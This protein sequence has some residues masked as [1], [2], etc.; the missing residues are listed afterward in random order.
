MKHTNVLFVKRNPTKSNNVSKFYY[1]I[2]IESQH[3]SGYTPP[4]IRSLK[5][6]WKPLGFHA[7]KVVGRAV[8]GRCQAHCANSLPSMKN[9]RLPVQI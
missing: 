3:V 1:S 7:S 8:S 9:Q 4:I 2:S 6:H 5:L